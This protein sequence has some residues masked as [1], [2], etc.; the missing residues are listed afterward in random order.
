MSRHGGGTGSDSGA[1]HRMPWESKENVPLPWR[2]GQVGRLPG[3]LLRS[4]RME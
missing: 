1:N 2:Q 3:E 4:R